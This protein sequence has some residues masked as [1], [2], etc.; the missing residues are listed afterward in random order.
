MQGCCVPIPVQW[1]NTLKNCTRWERIDQHHEVDLHCES[2]GW[3]AFFVRDSCCF[4]CQGCVSIVLQDVGDA[5][6]TLEGMWTFAS[7]HLFGGDDDA[8]FIFLC[9]DPLQASQRHRMLLAIL[10]DRVVLVDVRLEDGNTCKVEVLTDIIN[11]HSI[12]HLLMEGP[13][14][15]W[16]HPCCNSDMPGTCEEAIEHMHDV[17]QWECVRTPPL[18]LDTWDEHTTAFAMSQHGRL[19]ECSTVPR[20][21]D[22]GVL[23][24]IFSMVQR[25]PVPDQMSTLELLDW[26]ACTFYGDRFAKSGS[27]L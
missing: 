18:L 4:G 19:G 12:Q 24:K 9:K 13:M 17:V 14:A 23:Q 8:L 6:A 27:V 1:K 3:K 16:Y 15:R 2:V 25:E 20:T 5:S 22:C 10:D 11:L 7:T 21:L 26:L